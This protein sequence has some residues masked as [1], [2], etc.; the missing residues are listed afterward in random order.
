[1]SA[2][3]FPLDVAVDH[4][5][6]VAGEIALDGDG[7]PDVRHVFP[8]AGAARRIFPASMGGL[9]SASQR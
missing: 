4:Q 3:I 7:L 2:L 1:M 8:S 9:V 5:I 6:L